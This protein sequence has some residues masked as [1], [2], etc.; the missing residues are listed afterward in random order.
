M[1]TIEYAVTKVTKDG[2]KTIDEKVI[3]NYMA[4][5]SFSAEYKAIKSDGLKLYYDAGDVSTAEQCTLAAL[6]VAISALKRAYRN[7][8][9]DLVTDLLT[10]CQRYRMQYEHAILSDSVGGEWYTVHNDSNRH[11]I[12]NTALIG[13]YEGIADGMDLL[14]IYANGYKAVNKYF[15]LLGVNNSSYHGFEPL[16]IAEYDD[17]GLKKNTIAYLLECNGYVTNDKYFYFDDEKKELM[18]QIAVKKAIQDIASVLTPTQRR[19]FKLYIN[20]YTVRQIAETVNR[21]PSTVAVNLKRIKKY[22]ISKYQTF[23]NLIDM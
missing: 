23:D 4:K 11:D 9:T 16:P 20:G 13:I 12:V 3:D 6:Q 15:Y 1:A 2:K 8:P 14:G 7:S 18:H 19:I 21:Q 5:N 22:I 10:Y 17:D